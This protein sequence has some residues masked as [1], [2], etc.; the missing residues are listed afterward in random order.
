MHSRIHQ[1]RYQPAPEAATDNALH[2]SLLC[3]S[4]L[5]SKGLSSNGTTGRGC[6]IPKSTERSAADSLQQMAG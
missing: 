3:C 4:L 1:R 2:G 5:L 6:Q